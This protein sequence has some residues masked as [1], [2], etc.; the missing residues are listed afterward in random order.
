MLPS[1]E[2]KARHLAPV[3]IAMVTIAVYIQVINHGFSSFD[4]PRYVSENQRLLDGFDLKTVFWFFTNP[5]FANWH[6]LTMI[7]HYLD[8]SLFGLHAGPHHLVNL[9][10]HMANSLLCYFVLRAMTGKTWQSAVVAFL[11]SVHPLHVESVAW[12]S[13]RKNVLFAFFWFLSMGSYYRYVTRPCFF[14]YA[15]TFLLVSLSLTSKAMAVTLPFVFLLLDYWP[16]YRT[17]F[18]QQ[19]ALPAPPV[20]TINRSPAFLILEK[21]PFFLLVAATA[22]ITFTVQQNSGVVTAL[23]VLPLPER[24]G[25]A[26]MSY[27]SYLGKTLFPFQLAAFYPPRT[28]LSLLRVAVAAGVL[29][30]ATLL[31]LIWRRRLPFFTVGWFWFVGTLVPVIG[32]VQVGLQSMADRYTYIPIT[33]IFIAVVWSI[34]TLLKTGKR[35]TLILSFLISLPLASFAA[36][37]YHQTGYWKNDFTLYQ[38]AIDVT[39]NNFFAHN[40]L[41]AKLIASGK[42]Q[43]ADYHLRKAL[44]IRPTFTE[45]HYNMGHLLYITGNTEAAKQHLAKALLYRPDHAEAMNYM[46]YICLVEGKLKE[47]ERHFS[48]AVVLQPDLKQ[49]H[50]NLGI[51]LLRQKK[52]NAAA[53]SFLRALKH[54]P[55][56]PVARKYLESLSSKMSAPVSTVTEHQ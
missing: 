50:I 28:D 21:V 3:V 34:G 1:I 31:S 40:A 41:G 24:L 45:A 52:Y 48:K 5:Y 49:A 30:A 25:N 38:H 18:L 35:N 10:F 36:I 19:S 12:I 20:P 14:R 8:V 51:A 9:L 11:F 15:Q 46:G 29:L 23:D 16:L 22:I 37:S 47:A 54:S 17:N 39:K 42:Y 33:G 53:A 26:V 27:G 32:L 4:D 43:A 2:S 56:S 13:G 44:A 7:S 55:E 6:P